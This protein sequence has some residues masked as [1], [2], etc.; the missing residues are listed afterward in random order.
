MSGHLA[1]GKFLNRVS[2]VPGNEPGD[3]PKARYRLAVLKAAMPES[4]PESLDE[5]GT[6][7]EQHIIS[8]TQKLPTLARYRKWANTVRGNWDE[9]KPRLSRKN[10]VR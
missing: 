3:S 1:R 10:W 2:L 8:V 9:E 7:G 4:A 5:L 6:T